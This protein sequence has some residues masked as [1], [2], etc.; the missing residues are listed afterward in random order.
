MFQTKVVEKIKTHILCSVTIFL[1]KL[2]HWDPGLLVNLALLIENIQWK[3]SEI[4]KIIN[5][6]VHMGT[7]HFQNELEKFVLESNQFIS[8]LVYFQQLSF[9]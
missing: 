9:T 2:P 4:Y 7:T 3:K 8:V 1:V 6:L 5:Y